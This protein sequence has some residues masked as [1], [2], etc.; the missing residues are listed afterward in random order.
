MALSHCFR[1]T[2]ESTTI[3]N[4]DRLILRPWLAAD[5]EPFARINRDPAVMEFMPALLT[6]EESNSLVDR[7]EAHFEMHGFGLWAAELRDPTRF[8]GYVGLAVPR[9]LPPFT[10]AVEIGWR[11]ASD[12]WR[13]GLATEAAHAVVRHAFESLHLSALVSF[14]VPANLSSRSVMEKLD[15][16]NDPSDD[17]DHPLLPEGHPLRRHVLYRLNHSAWQQA[18][19]A[20]T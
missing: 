15:M 12:V 19:A 14:T 16:T 7:I 9:F 10:P 1:A 3:L 2:M 11:L 5:R 17:F 6:A 8:I 18:Q 13:Q 20:G 4:T